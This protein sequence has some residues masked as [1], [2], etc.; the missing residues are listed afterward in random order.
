MDGNFDIPNR[1]LHLDMERRLMRLVALRASGDDLSELSG[2]PGLPGGEFGTVVQ[3]LP[4]TRFGSV[5]DVERI[6][7]DLELAVG[8]RPA[9]THEEMCGVFYE[10]AL[11]A[12][13]HS[14]SAMGRYVVLERG[15]DTRS[16]VA[17][18]LGV[19]DLGI[20]IPA[21]LRRNP[22]FSHVQ[23]DADAIA[24]ATELHITGTGE[25]HRGIGLDHVINVVKDWRGDCSIISG[26]GY[27]NI[28]NGGD[29]VK[30]NLNSTNHISGTVAVVTLTAPAMR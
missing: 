5:A 9:G 3:V 22:H 21:S 13:E 12:V 7:D 17:H 18:V 16:G 26:G 23:N 28:Q 27:L 6:A 8:Q 25:A 2:E 19:A 4:L 1:T 30:G 10:L 20:G 15:T 11:N 29:L 14:R 24:L